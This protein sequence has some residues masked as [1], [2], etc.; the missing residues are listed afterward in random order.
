MKPIIKWTLWQRRWSILGWSFGTFALIFINMVFYP[1]FK[2][3]AAELQK[4]FSNLPD[5]AVQL[6]GGSTDFF[7][8][9]G[10]LNSQI[11]FLMLPMI[12]TVLAIA[13]GSSLI[14]REE[15]DGTLE[16]LLANP[17]SRSSLL[18]AK[19]TV[20]FTILAV[21]TFIGL[22]TTVI[23]AKMV[24]LVVPLSNILLATLA[25]FGLVLVI[26]TIAYF[27]AS[28]GRGRAFSI[29]IPAFLALGG[30]IISSLAGTV[31]WLK[32]PSK[33]LP[34][35]YYQSEAILNGNT[36]WS[37]IAVLFGV[38]LVFIALSFV[39]FRRRDLG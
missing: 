39:A 4:S 34:F 9:V 24:D 38:S 18:G 21:V 13:L 15:D 10:F 12:L 32:V 26:G 2:D 8:A 3:Q 27:I 23:L 35:H 11:Y 16:S 17:I 19:A 22:L 37:F 7:S 28:T 20:G 14:G 25:C 5:A 31:D 1:S 6:I 36:N 29:S 30:Y 33:F